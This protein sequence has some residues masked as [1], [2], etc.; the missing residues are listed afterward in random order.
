MI[1]TIPAR[2]LHTALTGLAKVTPRKASLPIL[3]GVLIEAAG[4][5]VRLTSTDLDS[6]VSY[7]VV[8]AAVTEPG[9][10]IVADA[11]RL[12]ELVTQASKDDTVISTADTL[13]RIRLQGPLGA[14][15][16]VLA[17]ADPTEWPPV[18][19]EIPGKWGRAYSWRVNGGGHIV[20]EWRNFGDKFWG[21]AAGEETW[22]GGG[23][24]FGGYHRFP[25]GGDKT[26]RGEIWRKFGN[27]RWADRK[28]GRLRP[29][30]RWL[31]GENRRKKQS[32]AG[33]FR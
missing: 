21:R 12:R 15:E 25:G 14:R 10:A 6:T 16:S 11:K 13:V 26:A 31:A 22:E 20:G 3:Q 17:I 7:T 2:E 8:N 24:G 19:P 18:P 30:A 1:L 33:R 29:A 4:N 5:T 27:F 23:P 9:L 28:S 32:A